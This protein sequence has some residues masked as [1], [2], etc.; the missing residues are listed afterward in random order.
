[1]CTLSVLLWNVLTEVCIP[2]S[3]LILKQSHQPQ[4]KASSWAVASTL[5]VTLIHDRRANPAAP[6]AFGISYDQSPTRPTVT[7][8][9]PLA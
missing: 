9:F 5:P 1:M 7:R 2:A 8:A 3:Q 6:P 4:K